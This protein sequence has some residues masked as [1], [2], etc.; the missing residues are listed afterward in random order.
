MRWRMLCTGWLLELPSSRKSQSWMVL[1]G[2]L[3]RRLSWMALL[4]SWGLL[5]SCWLSTLVRTTL[6]G[7]SELPRSC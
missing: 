7:S 3:V 4:G 5:R 1:L 2:S 6:L